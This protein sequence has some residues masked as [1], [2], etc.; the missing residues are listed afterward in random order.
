MNPTAPNRPLHTSYI[1]SF[2]EYC[3]FPIYLENTGD[4][5][6]QNLSNIQSKFG[7][8]VCLGC[9]SSVLP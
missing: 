3:C 8:F 9:R 5:K 7:S 2:C 4:L 6:Q 1:T